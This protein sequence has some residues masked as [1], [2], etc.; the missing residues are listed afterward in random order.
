[1][2][3]QLVLLILVISLILAAIRELGLLTPAI[4]RARLEGR[5][6]ILAARAG[7]TFPAPLPALRAAR[8]LSHAVA[9]HTGAKP[10]PCVLMQA[11]ACIPA[12]QTTPYALDRLRAYES[13]DISQLRLL[14]LRPGRYATVRLPGPRQLALRRSQG[15]LRRW[16]A[17]DALF[18]FQMGGEVDVICDPDFDLE[19]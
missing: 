2:Y 3:S 1:M 6:A 12:V 5:K 16:G 11:R 8:Q 7:E 18:L 19:G 10:E 13:I 15:A 17:E 4:P 9:A 14:R